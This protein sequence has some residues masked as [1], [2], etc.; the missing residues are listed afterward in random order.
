MSDL[1]KEVYDTSKKRDKDISSLVDQ[2]KDLINNIGDAVQLV[3]LI[4]G[5]LDTGVKNND[6]L[7]KMLSIIQKATSR[8]KTEDNEADI[9]EA[10]K[11]ELLETFKDYINSPSARA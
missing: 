6:L 8:V 10:E 1:L 2:L 11:Q 5:Y 7:V 4:N 9:S 3:P